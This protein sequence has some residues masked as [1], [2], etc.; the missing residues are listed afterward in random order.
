MKRY[1]N[2]NTFVKRHVLETSAV[3]SVDAW[4]LQLLMAEI[5]ANF[6]FKKVEILFSARKDWKTLALE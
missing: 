3:L 2:Y 5:A 4:P 1:C 6:L